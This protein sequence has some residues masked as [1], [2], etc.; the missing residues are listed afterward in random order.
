MVN[1]CACA[2]HLK[3][4]LFSILEMSS[5]VPVYVCVRVIF[6]AVRY[7]CR[8]RIAGSQDKHMF[9][10]SGCHLTVFHGGCTNLHFA[11][12]IL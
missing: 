3:E 8:N 5:L 7:T 10:F 2:I 1:C 11:S 4:S 12:N 6:F 9:R